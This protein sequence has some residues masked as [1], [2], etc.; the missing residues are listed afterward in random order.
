[1]AIIFEDYVSVTE[2]Q[3]VEKRSLELL[4]EHCTPEQ[5]KEFEDEDCLTVV[6]RQ[7]GARYLITDAR[8]YNIICLDD[9]RF[10][11]WPWR[12]A[13]EGAYLCFVPIGTAGIGDKFLMQKLALEHEEEI[14]FRVANRQYV[15]KARIIN[16]LDLIESVLAVMLGAIVLGVILSATILFAL[17]AV[18]AFLEAFSG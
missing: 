15:S 16:D 2:A 18:A 8:S 10:G 13:R 3:K 9:V 1:M 14:V 4:R 6:G 12:R 11:W 17:I 7:S 5:W